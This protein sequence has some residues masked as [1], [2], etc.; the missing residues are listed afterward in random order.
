VT[1]SVKNPSS[2]AVRREVVDDVLEAGS[3]LSRGL[4]RL[5][6]S[7]VASWVYNPF[8]YAWEAYCE[9][10]ERYLSGKIRG[11]FMGMNPGPWG[12]VQTGIPFGEVDA[13]RNW[14]K[15]TKQ[16]EPLKSFHP[17][18][19][20]Q[21]LACK[22]SEVSGKRLWGL[23]AARFQSPEIFFQ[24]YFVINYC[25]LAFLDSGARNLTPDKFP[26]AIRTSLESLCDEHLTNVVKSLK[27]KYFIGVG[28]FAEECGRR[29][30][31]P[32]TNKNLAFRPPAPLPEKGTRGGLSGIRAN[33]S[34]PKII[35]ILHPSPASPAA[36]R[37]WSGQVVSTLVQSGVWQ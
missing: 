30:L 21:G 23:F 27:P 36:N 33:S 26:A 4:S 16:A 34:G 1:R 13:V 11:L 2:K 12:M 29:C 10:V 5:D 17:K 9:Y 24:D 35:R 22:R 25:P 32:E 15:I 31:M 28:G 8:E 19:P 18:R 20:I 6:F 37:D 7:S 14:L 3:K